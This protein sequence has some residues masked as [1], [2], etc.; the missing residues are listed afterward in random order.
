MP[1]PD[2]NSRELAGKCVVRGNIAAT[3]S[4]NRHGSITGTVRRRDA[5][6]EGDREVIDLSRQPEP[7]KPV[8]S[9]PRPVRANPIP[10]APE[11]DKPIG[12]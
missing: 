6:P 4:L 1:K 8:R 11:S 2:I 10:T 7:A 5:I 12:K 3:F 9:I